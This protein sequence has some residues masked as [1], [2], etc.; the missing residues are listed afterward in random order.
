MSPRLRSLYRRGAIG[1]RAPPIGCA[2]L[3]LKTS[4]ENPVVTA[5]PA[6]ARGIT[7]VGAVAFVVGNMVG[8]SIYTLPASLAAEVGPLGIVAWLVAAVGFFFVALVYAS[9]GRRY[10]RT[11]GPYVYAREAFGEFIGFQTVWAYWFSATTG[12]AAIALGVV[13]YVVTFWPAVEGEAWLRFALGQALVWGLCALNVRGVRQ[14][15]RLQIV[16]VLLNVVPLVLLSAF[17][18]FT[19]DPAN[20][21]PFAPFGWSALPVGI[22]LVVWGYSGVE[23]ATVPAEEITAPERTIRL[24]T[25]IGYAIGTL[26]FLVTALAVAGTLPNAI[27]A[28]SARPIALAAERT[29]G[30]IAAYVISVAAILAG[31]GTLNG[32]ILMAG[33][34]P[35]SA[36]ADGVFFARLAAIHPRFRTP[37]VSLWIGGAIA[38][39]MLFLCLDHGLLAAFDFI[40]KL[41]VLTTL[42]P[43]LYSSAAE[44]MLARRDPHRYTRRERARAHVVAPIAFAFVMLTIYGIGP[45]VALWGL[46][47][48]LAGTPLYVVFKTR[49]A[50]GG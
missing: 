3:A 50:P 42:L 37:H 30:P 31:V 49:A 28:G 34:I 41:A 43:H 45:E 36:A 18:L 35:V 19:F 22:A 11:G 32:W 12:N 27:V 17:A 25:L 40:V 24:G 21:Q 20:L 38:S 10:P 2:H 14:S 6:L 39:A 33:R 8:T 48:V 16:I 15:A 23:S 44:L 5:R 26:V 7:L 9:L 47:V 46:L 29:S 13:G 1:S 4:L